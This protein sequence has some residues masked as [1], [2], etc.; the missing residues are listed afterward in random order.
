VVD[1]HSKGLA[2]LLLY[3]SATCLI[4][5]QKFSKMGQWEGGGGEGVCICGLTVVLPLQP[6]AELPCLYDIGGVC[7]PTACLC[8]VSLGLP[9]SL[10]TMKKFPKHNA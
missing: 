4:A 5:S 6:S 7:R 8:R 9:Q 10:L 2:S 3:P 1:T